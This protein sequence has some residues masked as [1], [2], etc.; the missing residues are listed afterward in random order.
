MTLVAIGS[1]LLSFLEVFLLAYASENMSQRIR[2]RYFQSVLRQDVAWFDANKYGEIVT[3]IVTDTGK[4]RRGTGEKMGEGIRFLSQFVTGFIVA[5][6]YGWSLTL[7]VMAC[8]PIL[9]ISGFFIMK[10]LGEK[11]SGADQFYA[12]VKHGFKYLTK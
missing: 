10:I 2:E 11:G 12:K 4:V 3:K 9:A 1:F 5:F 7:V 8:V 6:Y